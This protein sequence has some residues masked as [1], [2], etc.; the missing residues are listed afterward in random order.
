MVK[1]DIKKTTGSNSSLSYEITDRDGF[2]MRRD[3]MLY[4]QQHPR[5]TGNAYL[6]FCVAGSAEIVR[7]TETYIFSEGME[8]TLLPD[9]VIR[10]QH[11]SPDFCVR[12]CC[13][14]PRFFDEVTMRM[15]TAFL[16]YIA[17]RPPFVHPS[18]KHRIHA[19]TYFDLL[20]HTYEDMDNVFRRQIA[21]NLLQS[22]YMNFFNGV[23]HR[24][25]DN[26][27]IYT[28][29]DKLI[30]DF[31]ALLLKHH[32]QHRDV[33]WYADQLCVSSRYLSQVMH[34]Q[35]GLSPKQL[36]DDFLLME[37]Q[38]E[39][40]STDYTIQEISQ[41]LGFSSQSVLG[42]FFKQKTSVS[43]QEYRKLR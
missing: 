2:M 7:D 43:P 12:S 31:H 15:S 20:Q 33:V 18:E 29:K 13:F 21:V 35:A 6:L 17:V 9:N 8:W 26:Q 38:V 41:R 5:R 32:R 19:L 30:R 40:C 28:A 27:R 42:R 24:L 22:F 25:A 3:N 10:V 37:I 14:L 1:S 36:I 16:D 34:R 39:L 23:K 11:T 4:F